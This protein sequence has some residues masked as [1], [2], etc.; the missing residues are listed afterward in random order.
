LAAVAAERALALA[1]LFAKDI[2]AVVA[3]T[4]KGYVCPGLSGYV[5]MSQRD[6]D[7]LLLK[8]DSMHLA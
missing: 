6:C 4:C 3:S 8:T 7:R 5:T 1:G 2:D